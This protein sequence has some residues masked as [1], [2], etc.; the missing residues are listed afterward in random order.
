MFCNLT[1]VD[2]TYVN[3]LGFRVVL[4]LD[5]DRSWD[6]EELP[7]YLATEGFTF[8]A[9]T[10]NGEGRYLSIDRAAN[11]YPLGTGWSRVCGL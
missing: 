2:F 10:D 8:V 4:V 9:S 7:A 1:S 3:E 5:K 11:W 6:F